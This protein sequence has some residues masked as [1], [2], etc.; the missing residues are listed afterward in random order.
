MGQAYRNV[1]AVA[2]WASRLRLRDADEEG[3]PPAGGDL[4]LGLGRR[5][6]VEV[7]DP[8]AGQAVLVGV[9]SHGTGD[10]DDEEPR[11][12]PGQHAG[13]LRPP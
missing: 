12:R 6:D 4:R 1:A 7:P 9:V 11:V 10:R 8:V 2:Q 13:G 5:D 3:Q